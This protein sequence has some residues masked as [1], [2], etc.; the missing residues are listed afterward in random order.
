[1]KRLVRPD[2]A[3]PRSQGHPQVMA[4]AAISAAA[5]GAEM[6][7]EP[8][9]HVVNADDTT[10]EETVESLR[11]R[12]L[13]GSIDKDTW[14]WTPGMA[15]WESAGEALAHLFEPP[16][17]PATRAKEMPD[18]DFH[19]AG[20]QSPVPAAEAGGWLG[21]RRKSDTAN[22]LSGIGGWL[23]LPAIALFLIPIRII[24]SAKEY[25]R[26]IER[27]ET[28]HQ[29]YV[30][31]TDWS[32][33]IALSFFSLIV[34]FFFF[35]RRKGSLSLYIILLFGMAL[36]SAIDATIL[37]LLGLD[38]EATRQY[39]TAGATLLAAIIWT[40][41]FRRSR[42]VRNTFSP[43]ISRTVIEG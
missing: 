6:S 8:T 13:N 40:A 21:S 33:L 36:W 1:M 32:L 30:V 23:I 42:R 31:M 18:D 2:R 9:W 41:Y 34:A 5:A 7:A 26:A 12:V 39:L 14:A 25:L 27:T 3:L 28:D 11:R 22:R 10:S 17:R 15:E 38:E 37:S 19:E 29:F 35:K 24:T 20:V 4:A 43:Y 16:R